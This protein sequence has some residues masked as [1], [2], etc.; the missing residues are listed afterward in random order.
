MTLAV[1]T[2]KLSTLIRCRNV[3]VI[4]DISENIA[5]IHDCAPAEIPARTVVP[6]LMDLEMY[7]I[8]TLLPT[9]HAAV[10]TLIMENDVS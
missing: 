2:V 4:S 5:N 6:V 3:N 1:F 8:Q 10:Q 9:I 7:L